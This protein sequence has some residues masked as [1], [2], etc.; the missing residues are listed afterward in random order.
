MKPQSS[1]KEYVHS[2]HS[3]KYKDC[4]PRRYVKTFNKVVTMSRVRTGWTDKKKSLSGSFHRACCYWFTVTR[5]KKKST[6]WNEMLGH[7]SITGFSCRCLSEGLSFKQRTRL[8][9]YP[10]LGIERIILLLR[11]FAT[12][13]WVSLGYWRRS[14][15]QRTMLFWPPPQFPLLPLS[16]NFSHVMLHTLLHIL[17]EK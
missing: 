15:S 4:S 16:A 7:K 14:L 3:K 13:Q 11:S 2:I 1:E 5:K 12:L 17:L 9:C 10:I 6:A 8:R